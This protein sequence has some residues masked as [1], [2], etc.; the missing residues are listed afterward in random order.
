MAKNWYENTA[1]HSG[2]RKSLLCLMIKERKIRWHHPELFLGAE[3]ELEE[4]GAQPTC[5]ICPWV[6]RLPC[7]AYTLFSSLAQMAVHSWS[8]PVEDVLAECFLPASAS[9]RFVVYWQEVERK[10]RD[11][12]GQNIKTSELWKDCSA[13][14]C[15]KH[16]W[17]LSD[18][19]CTFQKWAGNKSILPVQKAEEKKYFSLAHW[20][21]ESL[22][23]LIEWYMCPPLAISVPVASTVWGNVL[24]LISW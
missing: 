3:E 9:C 8:A 7:S 22:Q 18:L 4:V 10:Q 21:I 1:L 17:C 6:P 23:P 13:I 11:V 19:P 14:S 12:E 24:S 15:T 16:L 5:K 20:K 2:K